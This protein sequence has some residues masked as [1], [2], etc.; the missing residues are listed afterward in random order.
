[1]HIRRLNCPIVNRQKLIQPV[2]SR[3][4]LLIVNTRARA[5]TTQG[6]SGTT[7]GLELP[8]LKDFWK[9]GRWSEKRMQS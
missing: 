9:G 4:V 8:F 3:F 6:D 1:M 5:R 7:I 2:R